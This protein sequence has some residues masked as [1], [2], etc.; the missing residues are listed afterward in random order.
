MISG[1][2]WFVYIQDG[3]EA[4]IAMIP[5]MRRV[6]SASEDAKEGMASFVERREAIFT[7]K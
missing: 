2:V 1:S 4:A 3:E 7:G 6:T 5:E